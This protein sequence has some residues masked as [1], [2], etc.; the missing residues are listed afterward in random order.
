MDRRIITQ[1][2]EADEPL[3]ETLDSKTYIDQFIDY[4]NSNDD[5]IAM[6]KDMCVQARKLTE[7]YT[8]LSLASQ[9][10]Q[11]FFSYDEIIDNDNRVVIP[12]CPFSAMTSEYPVSV[13]NEGTETALTLN[14]DYYLYG[15]LFKEIYIAESVGS[16]GMVISNLDY[17]IRFTAG[18]GITGDNATET[19]PEPLRGVMAK[20]VAEWWDNR[21][22][23]YPIL[24]ERIKKELLP[25]RRTPWFL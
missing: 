8:G 14:D 17:K 24:D 16:S 13:N 22:N 21:G 19:L 9:V 6:I 15:D 5:D 2:L 11:I 3:L 12:Y 4:N 23:Y 20:Q 18:Y 7:V 25:Y 10:V 1:V